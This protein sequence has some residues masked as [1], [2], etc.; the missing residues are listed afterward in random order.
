MPYLVL[1]DE[2][3]HVKAG[4]D[5]DVPHSELLSDAFN[6]ME[7]DGYLLVAIVPAGGDHGGAEYVFH[8]GEPKVRLGNMK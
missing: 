8:R 3:I 5:R 6:S 7:A 1:N 2:E 4:I